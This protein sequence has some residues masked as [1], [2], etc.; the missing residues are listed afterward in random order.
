MVGFTSPRSSYAGRWAARVT[1]YR[2]TATAAML[3]VTPHCAGHNHS[4]TEKTQGFHL[5]PHRHECK[6]VT[7]GAS[8]KIN[9][10]RARSLSWPGQERNSHVSS[11]YRVRGR[12]RSARRRA[13]VILFD[14]GFKVP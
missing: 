2:A 8:N 1:A 13:R 7:N 6:S 5:P 11:R 12:L 10:I 4:D 9:D 14:K 3:G